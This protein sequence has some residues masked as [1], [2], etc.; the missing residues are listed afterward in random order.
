M[1]TTIAEHKDSKRAL[2]E[3]KRA[4]RKG[5]K[6]YRRIVSYRK[7]GKRNRS[8][9]SGKEDDTKVEVVWMKEEEFWSYLRRN[10]TDYWYA[11]GLDNPKDSKRLDIAVQINPPREGVNLRVGGMFALDEIGEIHLCHT[12]AIG[13]SGKG[14]GKTEFW[15]RYRGNSEKVHVPTRNMS[16]PVVDLGPVTSKMLSSRIARFIREVARIKKSISDGDAI[17]TFPNSG[18]FT[19]EFSGKRSGYSPKKSIETKANHGLVVNTLAVAMIKAGHEI[20]ND[21]QRDMFIVHQGKGIARATLFEVKTD[22]SSTSIYQGVGQLMMN[23]LARDSQT[24]LILVVPGEPTF[25]TKNGLK[26]LGIDV[27]SYK[28]SRKKP[29]F[30]N[31]DEVLL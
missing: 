16:I 1:L 8:I 28:W 29:K 20:G 15:K 10:E 21:Q 19:P 2:E 25:D 23:G 11:F 7:S 9:V 3:M 4:L 22:V 24:N 6:P 27:L 13:G 5:S 31:L 26:K 14:V 30:T 17:Q 12:G 18:G